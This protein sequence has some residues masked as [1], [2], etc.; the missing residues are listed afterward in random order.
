M[1]RY[2][3]AHILLHALEFQNRLD[4]NKEN[5]GRM[6]AAVESRLADYAREGY[7]IA[8]E[9]VMHWRK[10]ERSKKEEEEYDT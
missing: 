5:I 2:N 8:S 6:R 1:Q 3:K 10:K 4:S 7:V 9:S